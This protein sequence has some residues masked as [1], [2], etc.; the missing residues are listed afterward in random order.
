MLRCGPVFGALAQL[1]E[2]FHGMEEARGSNPLS[3]TQERPAHSASGPPSRRGFRFEGP[4]R[5]GEGYGRQPLYPALAAATRFN[6]FEAPFGSHAGGVKSP[7]G[8]AAFDEY[9]VKHRLHELV[10]LVHP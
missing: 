10:A 1:V 5:N 6:H 2:R 9:V 3:S 7:A 8:A 4:L